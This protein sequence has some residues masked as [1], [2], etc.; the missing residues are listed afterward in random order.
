M[1]KLTDVEKVEA[2][3]GQ[4]YIT[5][6]IDAKAA[7]IPRKNSK[8]DVEREIDKRLVRLSQAVTARRDTDNVEQEFREYLKEVLFKHYMD[9]VAIN[10]F[11]YDSRQVFIRY[12]ENIVLAGFQISH[13]YLNDTPKG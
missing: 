3:S 10:D 12:R 13:K 6:L 4:I 1:I 9:P 5:V 8:G 2:G 7:E 11:I